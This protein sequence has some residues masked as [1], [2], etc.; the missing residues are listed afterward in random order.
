MFAQ[1]GARGVSVIFSS[2][3]SGPGQGCVS[4]DGLNRTIFTPIY[5]AGCPFVTSVGST[6]NIKPE[7]AAYFSS[8]GFSDTWARPAYQDAA[9]QNYF[10]STDTYTPFLPYFNETGRGTPDVSL[11]G[12]AYDVFIFGDVYRVDGTSASAP[13]FAGIVALL[14]DLRLQRGD[15]A[16]GF[17]NPWLYSSAAAAFND[18]TV[19]RSVG[20][21]GKKEFGKGELDQ[22]G[23]V[24]PN[25]GWDAVPGCESSF[26]LLPA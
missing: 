19:G 16:L 14:N 4:N 24:I 2:G 12:V 3:D 9:V 11:Q 10:E 26:Y 6:H 21:T 1:L 17:L 5:P 8:G 23:A 22:Q 18:I 13:A 20:C 7:K 25:A 15:S